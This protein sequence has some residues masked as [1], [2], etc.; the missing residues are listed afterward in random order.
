MTNK[1]GV[2]TL[3]LDNTNQDPVEV[4]IFDEFNDQLYTNIYN[5][6]AKLLKKFDIGK[7]PANKLTFVIIAKNQVF[8]RTINVR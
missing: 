8:N 5:D 2:V 7:A 3:S 4:I 1:N 6:S